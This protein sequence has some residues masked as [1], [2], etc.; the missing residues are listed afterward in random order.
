[1]LRAGERGADFREE[2]HLQKSELVG[3]LFRACGL[4][5]REQ[6]IEQ[7]ANVG[8]IRQHDPRVVTGLCEVALIESDEVPDVVREENS[9]VSR[10]VVQDG[11][12][13]EPRL[14]D[15]V[16]TEGINVVPS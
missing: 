7:A 12:V 3:H 4:K 2:G 14:L 13:Y 10:C 15:I 9:A 16:D 6:T 1:M 8:F 5:E 11:F